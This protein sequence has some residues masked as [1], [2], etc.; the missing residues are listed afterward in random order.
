MFKV[1]LTV[2]DLDAD[3]SEQAA[4]M[5]KAFLADGFPFEVIVTDDDGK[6]R[7]ITISIPSFPA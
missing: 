7:H 5:F 6:E 4:D 1:S 2:Q 3:S